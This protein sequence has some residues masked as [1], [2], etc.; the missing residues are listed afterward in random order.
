[1]S[2]NVKIVGKP[3]V[4]ITMTHSQ[5]WA[6]RDLIGKSSQ[7]DL[8]E[9]ITEEQIYDLLSIWKELNNELKQEDK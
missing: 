4:V 5:A 7:N 2:E 6:F 1:M 9:H 3:K 8:L